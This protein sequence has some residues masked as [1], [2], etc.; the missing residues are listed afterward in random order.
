MFFLCQAILLSTLRVWIYW[1]FT[2][3]CEVCILMPILQMR[4][5]D[6]KKLHFPSYKWQGLVF[7]HFD[8]VFV[9]YYA[10]LRLR[11]LSFKPRHFRES[12]RA[13]IITTP[14]Q[15]CSYTASKWQSKNILKTLKITMR[16]QV[17]WSLDV[18]QFWGS[19]FKKKNMIAM[20]TSYI[21]MNFF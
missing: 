1:I 16:V 17:F 11:N 4:K 6:I 20:N 10:I 5:W 13:L 19:S 2:A 12:K 9:I 7:N 21:K 18:V 14:R 3:I 8:A 15:H